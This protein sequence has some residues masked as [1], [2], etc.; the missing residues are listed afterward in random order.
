[1]KHDFSITNALTP[2]NGKVVKEI[3]ENFAKRKKITLST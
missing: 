1:M 3:V 2:K